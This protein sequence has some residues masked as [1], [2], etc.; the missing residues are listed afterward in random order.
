MLVKFVDTKS[1]D[2]SVGWGS[3]L[4]KGLWDRIIV[5]AD[6]CSGRKDI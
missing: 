6:G 5:V 3:I 2:C 4:D 1:P